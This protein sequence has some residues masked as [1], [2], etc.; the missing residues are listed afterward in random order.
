MVASQSL[1]HSR[2]LDSDRV[3]EGS[4]SA[5]PRE[6]RE[7]EPSIFLGDDSDKAKEWTKRA[8]TVGDFRGLPGGGS[9]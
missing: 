4:G 8:R 7:R 2:G 6:S 9:L 3:L 5:Q 1:H